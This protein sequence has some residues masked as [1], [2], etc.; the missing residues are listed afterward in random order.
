MIF[1]MKIKSPAIALPIEVM[2]TA[3]AAQSLIRLT[4][5]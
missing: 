2:R 1:G 4:F 5:V 3:P